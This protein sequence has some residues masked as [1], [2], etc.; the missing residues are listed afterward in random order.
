MV[1]II[2]T[3]SFIIPMFDSKHIVPYG[4][5]KVTDGIKEKIVQIKD[6]KLRQY[7][8]FNYRRYYVKRQGPLYN[9]YWILE[10]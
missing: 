2:E 10:N 5:L 8:T 9:S 1:S 4:K 6:D 3:V 7:F